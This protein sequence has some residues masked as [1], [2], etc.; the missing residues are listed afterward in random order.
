MG[1]KGRNKDTDPNTKPRVKLIEEIVR[2]NG[3]YR[4]RHW[5]ITAKKRLEIL[6]ENDSERVLESDKIDKITSYTNARVKMF[7]V[8]DA[9]LLTRANWKPCETGFKDIKVLDMET[10]N[11]PILGMFSEMKLCANFVLLV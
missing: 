7:L 3:E 8:N 2:E 10:N 4:P 11:A 6:D 1:R 5:R 9:Y